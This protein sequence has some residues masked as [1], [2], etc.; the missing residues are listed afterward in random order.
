M[1]PVGELRS[2]DGRWVAVVYIKASDT[3]D[4]RLFGLDDGTHA[5]VEVAGQNPG[6]IASQRAAIAEARRRFS[7]LRDA[8]YRIL[9]AE[10]AVESSERSGRRGGLAL[11]GAIGIVS[12]LGLLR[13]G[14][15]LP[16]MAVL[17]VGCVGL[18]WSIGGFGG[19]GYGGSNS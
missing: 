4:I 19:G 11:L 3:F 9:A 14:L 8:S 16:G 1:E 7:Q 6:D 5:W 18:G 17:F 2:A 15:V 12:G 10:E 13:F